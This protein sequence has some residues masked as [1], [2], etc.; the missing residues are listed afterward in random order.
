VPIDQE[1]SGASLA[2]LS[3]VGMPVGEKLTLFLV[4]AAG[5]LELKV[6]V[7]AVQPRIID[8]AVLHRLRL[9]ILSIAP[10]TD[11]DAGE[12]VDE[13]PPSPAARRLRRH[14]RSY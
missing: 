11:E 3:D 14:I 7:I 5:R 2:V 12:A 9:S 6:K 4:G 1:R 8:G 10:A 13:G